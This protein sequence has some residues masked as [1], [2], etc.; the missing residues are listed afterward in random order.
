[1]EEDNIEEEQIKI[2]S[3]NIDSKQYGISSVY[4]TFLERNSINLQPSYQRSLSWSYEKMNLF[5]DSLFYCPVIPSFILYKLHNKELSELRIKEKESKIL[6][7][8]IDGQHRLTVIKYFM[9]NI[10]IKIGDYNKYLYIKDKNIDTSHIKIFYKI[11]A[12]LEN[13][14]KK[15][16]IRE[17]TIDEKSD[18]E[19]T[20]LSVQ[21]ITRF[22]TNN[23]KCSLFNRLQNGEKVNSVSKFKN[24]NHPLTNFLRENNII[25]Y[26]LVDVWKK[27]LILN[28]NI[29]KDKKGKDILV[30]KIALFIIKLI[31]VLDKKTPNF[32]FLDSNIC[33]SIK[34]NCPLTQINGNIQELYN[35]VLIIKKNIEKVITVKIIEEFYYLLHYLYIDKPLLFQNINIL[36]LDD[37]LFTQFNSV[38]TYKNKEKTLSKDNINKKYKE[39]VEFIEKKQNLPDKII[40]NND[41]DN[42]DIIITPFYKKVLNYDNLK[43]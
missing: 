39:M 24:E 34:K 28:E 7:E 6:F 8:C 21:T 17:M 29:F 33:K 27:I 20:T 16:N 40:I 35:N 38:E 18:F 42:D 30:G 23:E 2:S 31:L 26:S 32:S 14:Y 13:K 5:L 36:L 9:E 4:Y 1:M 41:N 19:N 43:I 15:K 25:N 12:E 22:L 10:P 37:E 11:T 3:N